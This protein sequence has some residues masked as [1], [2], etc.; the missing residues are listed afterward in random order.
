M[1]ILSFS[2]KLMLLALMPA[3]FFIAC[4]DDDD[5]PT[6]T[7]ATLHGEITIDNIELWN[8][9]KDSGDVQI[10]LFPEFVLAAP[11]A[12]K[13]WGVIPDNFFGPGV[14][15]GTYPI[16]A[17]V[18]TIDSVLVDY[19]T[20]H[21]SVHY[22]ME[23]EPGTYSALAIGFRHNHIADPNLRTATLG[24]HWNNPTTVSHGVVIKIDIGGG[25]IIPIFNEPAPATITVEAGDEVE[26]DF[27][28]DFG[29]VNEWFQ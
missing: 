28:A 27:R 24:V 10:T 5:E 8:T 2:M 12:G 20:G 22:E 17:P 13:G 29:F 18:V 26:L 19:Q 23:V 3:L 15:G 16:S 14:P 9:W 6:P 1:K 21:T 25:T 11:P 7:T 4:D